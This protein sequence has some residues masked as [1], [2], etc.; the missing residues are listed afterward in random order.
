MQG[1]RREGGREKGKQREGNEVE[2]GKEEQAPGAP[3]A[4]VCRV[5]EPRAG[6]PS[7]V[8]VRSN[9]HVA[10]SPSH[11]VF[12]F[13]LDPPRQPVHELCGPHLGPGEVGGSPGAHGEWV[14][15]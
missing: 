9:E 1:E 15:L 2:G 4:A 11:V 6:P 14:S 5:T 7:A 3:G 10:P 13:G 12:P 8:P